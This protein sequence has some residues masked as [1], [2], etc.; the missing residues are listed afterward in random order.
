MYY[1]ANGDVWHLTVFPGSLR[2]RGV[3][4]IL[5]NQSNLEGYN[6]PGPFVNY[7]IREFFVQ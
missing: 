3:M 4:V 5:Q 2:G 1:R 7:I 6:K